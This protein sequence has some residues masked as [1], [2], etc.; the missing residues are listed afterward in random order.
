MS[1]DGAF[2]IGAEVGVEGKID[3][4]RGGLVLGW[5]WIDSKFVLPGTDVRVDDRFHIGAAIAVAPLRDIAGFETLEMVFE[6]TH[7]TLSDRPWDHEAS[8]PVEVGG[9]LRYNGKF[10]A[11]AGV[12]GTL[13]QGVGAPDAR[14]VLSLGYAF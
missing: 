14:L 8:S 6:A 2:T 3:W 5:E 9:A 11:L 13:N 12:S 10:F 4:V 7:W 1:N